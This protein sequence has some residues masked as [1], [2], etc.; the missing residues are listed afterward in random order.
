MLETR[1]KIGNISYLMNLFVWINWWCWEKE[2]LVLMIDIVRKNEWICCGLC[3]RAVSIYIRIRN[4]EFWWV[5]RSSFNVF[6]FSSQFLLVNQCDGSLQVRLKSKVSLSI[7][8]VFLVNK[9]SV[10]WLWSITHNICS[11]M[12]SKTDEQVYVFFIR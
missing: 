8:C 9:L 11:I 5:V 1:E 7:I 12:N 4:E 3:K 6:P 10:F 2:R